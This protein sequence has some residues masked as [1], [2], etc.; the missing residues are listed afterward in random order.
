MK[1]SLKKLN[2]TQIFHHFAN[3]FGKN[4]FSNKTS[5]QFWEF[6]IIYNQAKKK[7]KTLISS[8]HEKLLTN[9]Q[10]DRQWSFHRN[11]HFPFTRLQYNLLQI[12]IWKHI[13]H[14][15]MKLC[16][17]DL[18]RFESTLFPFLPSFLPSQLENTVS[19]TRSR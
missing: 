15:H 14:L 7:H 10:T 18:P 19:P 5:C 16:I 17:L 4:E 3:F 13:Y 12:Y 9:G 8:Y 11:L 6:T 1:N 2:K